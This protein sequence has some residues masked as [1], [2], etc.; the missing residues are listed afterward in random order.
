LSKRQYTT[1]RLGRS[2]FQKTVIFIVSSV[3]TLNVPH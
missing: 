3:R 1:T 2:T